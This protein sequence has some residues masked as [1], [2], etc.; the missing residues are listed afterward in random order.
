MTEGVEEVKGGGNM[1][2]PLTKNK[3]P[4]AQMVERARQRAV[5]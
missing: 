4:N 2:A 3:Q 1:N 5:R